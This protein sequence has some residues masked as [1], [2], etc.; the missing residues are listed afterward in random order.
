ME[1]ADNPYHNTKQEALYLAYEH[2]LHSLS[3]E[4]NPYADMPEMA[5]ASSAWTRGFKS[6]KKRAKVVK[7]SAL[8]KEEMLP[9]DASEKEVQLVAT[10]PDDLLMQELKRRKK[11]EYDKLVKEKMSLVE[12]L[13]TV[14][15]NLYHLEILFRL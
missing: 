2:G 15:Q 1:K 6:N 7:P 10:L 3:E 8:T 9:P 11:D 12:K 4:E 13:D 5:S 14:Q